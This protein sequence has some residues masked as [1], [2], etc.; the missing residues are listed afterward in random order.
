MDGLNPVS[1]SGLTFQN[2][3][4]LAELGSGGA[5]LVERTS[6]TID[7]CRLSDNKATSHGALFVTGD[8]AGALAITVAL[9]NTLFERNTSEGYGGAVNL[10]RC[11]GGP[12]V[13]E[14]CSF[15][16]NTCVVGGGAISAAGTT[17]E[18][19]DC[20]FE[21]NEANAGSAF[22][23]SSAPL[24]A[25]NNRVIGNTSRTS[26]GA[27]YLAGDSTLTDN[28]IEDNTA[29]DSGGAVACSGSNYTYVFDNNTIRRNHA[30]GTGGGALYAHRCTVVLTDNV[31]EG[32][33]ATEG[34]G[35]YLNGT[36]ATITGNTFSANECAG[37]G[38]ALV[39]LGSEVSLNANSIIG[40]SGGTGGIVTWSP[41]GA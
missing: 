24:I 9:T 31:I 17:V 22:R 14:G 38:A 29:G 40:N 4:V 32:N 33:T 30:P 28:V 25:T 27:F 12:A 10:K 16:D 13:I 15:I 37:S 39:M 21:G 11:Y 7:S 2:G 41:G 3:D 23:G 19:T 34:G 18:L 26:W 6:I 36:V 8:G 5:I 20:D 35:A 1:L